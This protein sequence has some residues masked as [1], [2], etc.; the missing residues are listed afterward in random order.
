MIRS[1]GAAWICVDE[2]GRPL[3]HGDL[4]VL[5]NAA[6]AG[7]LAPWARWR[8]S[9]SRG[10]VSWLD[11]QLAG[12]ALPRLPLARTGYAFSIGAGQLLCGATGTIDDFDPALREADHRHNLATLARLSRQPI[13]SACL[14]ALSGR[15]A[16]RC[17]TPDRL[18]VVG[19]VPAPNH[20]V[21]GTQRPP[22]QIERQA[23]LFVCTALGARGVTL[24]PLLA[25][26]LAAQMLGAPVPLDAGLIDAIDPARFVA[27]EPGVIA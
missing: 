12:L 16:W 15:V 18:P 2:A 11:A 25:R 10:Q 19:P 24:A 3:A 26:S 13:N 4:L 5:A 17:L 21:V 20:E 22:R 1:A 14:D 8:L 6:D 27:R 7:R 23:G 9:S